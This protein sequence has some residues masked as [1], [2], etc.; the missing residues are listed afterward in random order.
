MGTDLRTLLS[1][2]CTKTWSYTATRDL[3]FQRRAPNYVTKDS[4]DMVLESACITQEFSSQC[5]RKR[6]YKPHFPVQ[7]ANGLLRP[8]IKCKG[9]KQDQ[10]F[11]VRFID[12]LLQSPLP[13]FSCLNL[14]KYKNDLTNQ[15]L[16]PTIRKR[17]KD[18]IGQLQNWC[19]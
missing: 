7:K 2:N 15:S 18:I 1:H 10:N 5:R 4:L 9:S 19:P 13:L 17:H 3:S 11:G 14:S 6:M 8:L 12:L 16:K